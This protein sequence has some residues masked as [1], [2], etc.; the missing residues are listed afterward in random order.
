MAKTLYPR[1]DKEFLRIKNA[2]RKS[3]KNTTSRSVLGPSVMRVYA[4]G[5]RNALMPVLA[6]EI[7]I[8]SLAAIRHQEAFSRWFDIQLDRLARATKPLNSRNHR[9]APGAK[10]GH[11]TKILTLFVRDLV[12]KSRYF[13]DKDARRI[14]QFLHAPIDGIVIKRLRKLRVRLPFSRIKDIDTRKKFY[15]VQ[16]TLTFAASKA[17]IPRVWFDDNWGD[18]Q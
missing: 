10:W 18:R 1:L 7:D 16:E 11:A 2:H 17:G 3:L 8:D 15:D 12:L 5:T 4:R 14:S 13:T 6:E 9:I